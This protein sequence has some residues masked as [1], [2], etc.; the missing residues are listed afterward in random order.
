MRAVMLRLP[1]E[2][3]GVGAVT[4]EQ[5]WTLVEVTKA[6]PAGISMSEL[7]SRRGMAMNSATALVDRLSQA[8]LLERRPD[9]A[10]R[11]VVR[12]GVT[13]EGR[14]LREAISARRRAEY[15]RLLASLS[16]EELQTLHAAVP[17]LARLAEVAAGRS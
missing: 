17:A 6:D 1:T 11:R 5:W 16:P 10:D 13:D 7:A 2:A 9:P 8:G 15:E 4:Q 3:P 14:R 12:V